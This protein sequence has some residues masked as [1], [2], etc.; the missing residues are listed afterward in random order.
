MTVVDGALRAILRS[1]TVAGLAG[2]AVFAL[3]LQYMVG[4]GWIDRTVVPKPSAVI[5]AFPFVDRELDLVGAFA[6]T[7]GS[8]VAATALSL[9]V[10][11][12]LG[13]LLYRKRAFGLAYEGW[14][15]AGFA[16]PTVLLYPL[17]L[18]IFGR[19]ILMLVLMS[20]IPGTIPIAIHV[21]HGLRG[22][23]KALINVGRSLNVPQRQIFWKIALPAATPTIFAGVRVGVMYILINIIAVE[24]LIN[25]GGLGRVVSEMAF[26]FEVPGTYAGILLVIVVSILFYW[27]MGRVERWLR[28]Q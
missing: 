9:A 21:Y 24:F 2:L 11:V 27:V 6:S 23:P 17:F 13:Y 18:V 25:F 20:A 16:A 3:A 7:L 19:T 14:L 1:P 5:A 28:P 22:V 10:G 26:R 4:A 12:P 8:T 15:T